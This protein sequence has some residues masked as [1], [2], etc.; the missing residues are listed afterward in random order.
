MGFPGGASGKEPTWQC[1]RC[2]RLGFHPWVRKIP[3]RRKR[4]PTPVFL[5]GES[6]GQRSMA[7][8]SPQ[9]TKSRTW[10]KQLSTSTYK[11][12][13]LTSL[14]LYNL[15][16][17]VFVWSKDILS[18]TTNHNS[19]YWT[20]TRFKA[21]G[22]EMWKT[23]T[24]PQHYHLKGYNLFLSSYNHA[25]YIKFHMRISELFRGLELIH[26]FPFS[27]LGWGDDITWVQTYEEGL[28]HTQ[29]R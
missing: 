1:R 13:R 29:K 28:F 4:Q 27:V 14:L 24:K 6:H 10:L 20:F 26:R 21:M 3:W 23:V 22:V 9:V 25:L 18:I 5:P 16:A 2:K 15:K 17:R 12:C 8:Y 7:G 19:I 11:A